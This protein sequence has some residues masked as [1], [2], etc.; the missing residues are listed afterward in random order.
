M[1]NIF[2]IIFCF[3]FGV[4]LSFFFCNFVS[5][6]FEHLWPPEYPPRQCPPNTHSCASPSCT[7]PG[8]NPCGGGQPG[9]PGY[10]KCYSC[11]AGEQI[12]SGQ[13]GCVACSYPLYNPITGGVCVSCPANTYFPQVFVPL[14]LKVPMVGVPI[15]P[16]AFLSFLWMFLLRLSYWVSLTQYLISRPQMKLSMRLWEKWW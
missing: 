4:I 1:Y 12:N 15:F 14:V 8:S 6:Y 13:S 11:N 9:C 16:P 3:D 7:C 5:N 2:L 10:T